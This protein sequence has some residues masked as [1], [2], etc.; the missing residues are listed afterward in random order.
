MTIAVHIAA[1]LLAVCLGAAVLAF[2][3]GTARHKAMG[4]A[5]VVLM[6]IVAVGSFWIRELNDGA[7][8][9]IHILSVATLASLALAIW[10][11]RSGR[12]RTHKRA[13]IGAFTGLVAAGL[14]T[15]AP[16][17]EIGRVL[18]GGL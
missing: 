12:V 1:A 15:L 2:P 5:W 7:P 17:R 16:D 4:R 3:K 14:F 13:M 18:F 11:V 10:A 9:A 8:S 6:V